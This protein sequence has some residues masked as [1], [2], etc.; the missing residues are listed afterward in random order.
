MSDEKITIINA[1]RQ[2]IK[3]RPG[4]EYGNYGDPL[5]YRQELRGIRK[6]GKEAQTMLTV[7][8][9]SPIT[10]QEL[11]HAFE[12][13][14]PGRLSWDGERLDYCAGQY[15]C[16][17]YRQAVCAVLATALWDHYRTEYA[18][19]KLS[20]TESDGDAIRRHFRDMFGK[21]IQTRWFN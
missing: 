2:W 1:L 12:H 3:Q 9:A 21:T 11:K 14:F 16:T 17:E 10:A 18:K 7:V 20:K 5:S 8:E 6:S 4:L 15:W 13:A 19:D